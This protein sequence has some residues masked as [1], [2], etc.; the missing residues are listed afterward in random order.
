MGA[1][2]DIHNHTIFGVDDGS[3]TLEQSKKML[4]IAYDE[5]IRGIVLTPH[6]NP[7]RW[8]FDISLIEERFYALK[9]YCEKDFPKLKLFL[10]SELY[11]GKDTLN[12][13]ARGMSFTM[14]DG[15]YIMVEFST[16]VN[17]KDI[18]QAVMDIQQSGYYPILAHVERYVCLLENAEYVYEL[19]ELGAFIQVNASGVMGEQNKLEKKFIKELL[20]SENVDFV[21]TDAH[22]DNSRAPYLKKCS[23]Y[24]VKRYGEEYTKRILRDNPLKVIKNQYIGE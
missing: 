18:R 17:Y 15:D 7:Y 8:L 1:M 22:R 14:A 4:K 11:Y 21:A 3:K 16:T 20:L 13:L 10:G 2:I 5:G 12:D 19:K 24:L 6:Y 23:D 9:E